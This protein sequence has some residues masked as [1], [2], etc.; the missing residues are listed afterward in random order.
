MSFELNFTNFGTDAN[1]SYA[2]T[3]PA[4]K[5][6]NATSGLKTGMDFRGQV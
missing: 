3:K 6:V 2:T 5:F 4:G 1:P